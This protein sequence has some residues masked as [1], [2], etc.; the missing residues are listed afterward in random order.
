MLRLY[1]LGVAR[2]LAHFY[3]LNPLDHSVDIL[4]TG[5]FRS[6]KQLL[7][8]CKKMYGNALHC[9]FTSIG[10]TEYTF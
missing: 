1:S 4:L 7:N 6:G 5:H 10:S 2:Y 9:E 3:G 8:S